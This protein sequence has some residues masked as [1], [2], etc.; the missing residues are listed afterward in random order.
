MTREN[1]IVEARTWMGTPYL[2]Q[3]RSRTSGVDCTG[4]QIVVAAQAGL[5]D[6]DEE[7]FRAYPRLPPQPDS[8]PD[9]FRQKGMVEVDFGDAVPGDVAMFWMTRPVAGVAWTCHTAFLTDV[10][11]LHTHQGIGRVV[12]H[13][14]DRRWSRRLTYVFSFPQLVGQPWAGSW[15]ELRRWLP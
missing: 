15:E 7:S 10:G 3:G 9:L 5:G 4:L 8:L 1:L 13:R 2:H 6:F 12:E 11:L 14:I